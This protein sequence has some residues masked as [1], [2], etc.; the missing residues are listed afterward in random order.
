MRCCGGKVTTDTHRTKP[1]TET[2]E[3]GA[4]LEEKADYSSG[5]PCRDHYSE[6]DW[7]AHRFTDLP[8]KE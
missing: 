8:L 7:H 6:R 4:R 1:D 5:S 3:I 2:G